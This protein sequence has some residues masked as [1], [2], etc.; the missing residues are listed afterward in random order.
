MEHNSWSFTCICKSFL[1][2]ML[3]AYILNKE[4]KYSFLPRTSNDSNA[5]INII[6]FYSLSSTWILETSRTCWKS[7]PH[8]INI[9]FVFKGM[10]DPSEHSIAMITQLNS[11][12]LIWLKSRWCH[13]DTHPYILSRVSISEHNTWNVS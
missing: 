13:F 7:E 12:S 11:L 1:W 8:I 4:F 10:Y 5:C 2:T 3:N 9:S 6:L